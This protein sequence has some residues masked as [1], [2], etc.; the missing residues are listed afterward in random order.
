MLLAEA[1]R[2]VRVVTL[3]V[4][5][6]LGCANDVASPDAGPTGG[7][8]ALYQVPTTTDLM[9]PT[10]SFRT[11]VMPLFHATCSSSLCH[12]SATAPAG[13]VFLGSDAEQV[14]ANLV[15]RASQT[16][17][18]M[19]LVT[20]GS[21]GKSFLMHKMDADQCAYAATCTVDNCGSQMPRDSN[22][23]LA[24][25]TRDSVRRWIAQGAEDN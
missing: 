4:L 25:Q 18:T 11:D 21:P 8:C 14:Y 7:T 15:G 12:G 22:T 3:L 6:A 16:L 23:P 17:P 5:V 1:D 9:M 20:A 19:A 13:A 2:M 10:A 24:A